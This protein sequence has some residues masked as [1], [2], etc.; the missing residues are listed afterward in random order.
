MRCSKPR[1]VRNGQIIFKSY[2]FNATQRVVCNAGFRLTGS[3]VRT[4]RGKGYWDGK[5]ARCRRAQKNCQDPGMKGLLLRTADE[6]TSFKPGT[7]LSYF[8]PHKF[9]LRG[10]RELIC[11]G[12]G[13]WSASLPK[14]V[15]PKCTEAVLP[16]HTQVKSPRNW[17]NRRKYGMRFTLSCQNGYTSTQ[18]GTLVCDA[19]GW[20]LEPS[21]FKC[22]PVKNTTPKIHSTTSSPTGTTT[23]FQTT[24]ALIQSCQ[25]P[26][27]PWRGSKNGNLHVGQTL[28]FSCAH[29]YQLRGSPTRTCQ[30]DLSWSGSQPTCTA[31]KCSALSH[32]TNG[33]IVAY[34][35]FCG[36][37][38]T[39]FK[40]YSGYQ[41][42]GSRRTTCQNDGRW[43][44]TSPTCV[45]VKITTP[46]ID[47]KRS[48][49]TS[50]TATQF[51]TIIA[52]LSSSCGNPVLPPRARVRIHRGTVLFIGCKEN[53]S[54]LITGLMRCVGN[55]WRRIRDPNCLAKSCSNP[56]IPKNGYKH[57][58]SYF[59]GDVVTFTCDGCYRLVG[60]SKRTCLKK[61]TW[62][63]RQPICLL[64]TC[65]K[66]QDTNQATV[67]YIS[68]TC[69]SV[70]TYTCKDTRLTMLGSG[71]KIC[72]K[73]GMWEGAEPKCINPNLNIA[74]G[75]PASMSSHWKLHG[76]PA[77]VA[78]DGKRSGIMLSTKYEYG[79]WIKIDLL[80]EDTVSTVI[81]V[82]R[83]D[84]CIRRMD[85]FKVSVGNNGNKA[86]ANTECGGRSRAKGGPNI[87]QCSTTLRG[88]Y[89]FVFMPEKRYTIMALF[90]V[91]VYRRGM[92]E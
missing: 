80:K 81:V 55:T 67:S 54:T 47:T 58:L 6:T 26:G 12:D 32:P 13:T 17:R 15:A 39:E 29:C 38:Q 82:N 30:S 72:N 65:S 44:A 78:A 57:G 24:D 68:Q 28:H 61:G 56:G 5:R 52:L 64:K 10:S 45:P 86:G 75:K 21:S 31:I 90:E 40:C 74:L 9:I 62:S 88:R 2:C 66:L 27:T 49:P 87:I 35:N 11:N 1:K 20:R 83:I 51:Q 34:S 73:S 79:S 71:E 8:C 76:G 77:S 60:N 63:Y 22:F 37:K 89:V 3:A 84:C 43:S 14:C 91:E 41:L 25:D 36:R 92:T 48:Q 33:R 19:P 69:D 42:R 4:C 23:Q 16:A 18:R 46:R 85:H 59:V 70:A 7:K 50:T 53:Y